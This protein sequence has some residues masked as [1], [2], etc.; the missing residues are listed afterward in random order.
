MGL[1]G[2]TLVDRF[3]CK[4]GQWVRMPSYS[5]TAAETYLRSLFT[6]N[7]LLGSV[8]SCSWRTLFELLLNSCTS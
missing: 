8:V 1:N 7:R 6:P 5:I 2:I 4:P 3:C